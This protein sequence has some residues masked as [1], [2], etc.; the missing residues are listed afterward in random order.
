MIRERGE[1]IDCAVHT[2][3]LLLKRPLYYG[4]ITYGIPRALRALR[5][6]GKSTVTVASTESGVITVDDLDTVGKL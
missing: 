3:T 1:N 4:R 6:T 5:I 2:L